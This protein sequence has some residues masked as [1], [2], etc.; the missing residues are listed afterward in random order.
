MERLT[1]LHSVPEEISPHDLDQSETFMYEDVEQKCV[2][3]G[4]RESY[5]PR[6][7]AGSPTTYLD[8][9]ANNMPRVTQMQT[10]I[11]QNTLLSWT[12]KHPEHWTP[13][14][15]L[16]WIYFIADTLQIDATTLRGEAFQNI[17]GPQLCSMTLEDFVRRDP[18]NGQCFHDMF[19]SI[20][21]DAFFYKP[22]GDDFTNTFDHYP[23]HSEVK[24]E[25]EPDVDTG[26]LID[27]CLVNDK[28]MSVQ[29]GQHWYPIDVTESKE[30]EE[31]LNDCSSGRMWLQERA[32]YHG[33]GCSSDSESL[34]GSSDMD[35]P[36]LGGYDTIRRSS[37]IGSDVISDD[38]YSNMPVINQKS[39]TKRK[40]TAQRRR[41]TSHGDSTTG[42]KQQ[43]RGRKPGQLSKGNHLWEF[44]RDLLK[45]PKFNPQLLRWEE[46]DTGV[47]R[48]VQ[49]EAVAQMWGRKKNNPGMTYEKLSRAMR[50]CRSAGYFAEVPKTGKFPKKLCF[51]FGP[52]AYGWGES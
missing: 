40:Y 37:S 23:Y 14:E 1:T 31:I 50:F 24:Q 36:C 34:S 10:D 52:K 39:I 47:F 30:M 18:Q 26:K 16:D 42:E 5:S 6:S 49:S 41:H 19:M 4:R 20:R 15:V 13:S 43:N 32:D 12:Q 17:G 29:L 48:F 33:Y 21:K 22:P 46:K 25:Y 3:V 28:E 45:D 8:I 38:D 27:S 51:R 9:S 2:D 7:G 35:M 44:I 11:D